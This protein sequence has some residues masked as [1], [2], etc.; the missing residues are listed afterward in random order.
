MN[1]SEKQVKWAEDIKAETARKIVTYRDHYQARYEQRGIAADD[2]RWENIANADAA[3]AYMEQQQESKWFIDNLRNFGKTYEEA[4][5]AM[6]FATN[7]VDEGMRA[8]E[9]IN[10]LARQAARRAARQAA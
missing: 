6:G 5:G 9:L 8:T 2:P 7:L 10:G 1:G 4:P 3:L